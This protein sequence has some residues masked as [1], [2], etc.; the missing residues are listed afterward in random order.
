M[1]PE[2]RKA[3]TINDPSLLI[4]YGPIKSGKTT[5]INSLDNNLILDLEKGT[6]YLNS[7]SV[8]IIGIV[9]PKK[10]TEDNKKIRETKKE[11]YLTEIGKEIVT[12]GKKYDFITLDTVTMFEEMLKIPALDLYKSTSIGS[13]FEGNDILDLARGAGYYYIRKVYD[14]YIEKLKKLTPRLILIGHLKENIVNKGT[15]EVS[16]KEIDLVGKLKTIACANADAV[17]YLYRGEN[18][19]IRITFKSSEEI[20]C[21][22]RCQHLKGQDIK[23]AD[24]NK[25]INDLENINWS[26]IYPDMFS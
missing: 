16:S 26:L 2:V 23:I 20:V 15:K 9:P 25:E 12:S 19:E 11:Y 8:N 4:I 6:K 17:G 10:E 21:G 3:S 13:T 22:S 18:S 1:L 7:L 5:L 14:E 24:Y